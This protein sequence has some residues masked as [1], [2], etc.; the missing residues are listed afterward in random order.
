MT[1]S[2]NVIDEQ[3][4]Y[5]KK[6]EEKLN[7]R[8]KFLDEFYSNKYQTT[9][10]DLEQKIKRADEHNWKLCNVCA[11]LIQ[12]IDCL[13]TNRVISSELNIHSIDEISDYLK[14]SAFNRALY[15]VNDI[16]ISALSVVL[17]TMKQYTNL[18]EFVDTLLESRPAAKWAIEKYRNNSSTDAISKDSEGI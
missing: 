15:K 6:K 2:K 8:E 4:E 13:C 5:L 17:D 11:E 7:A 10:E 3:L 12:I 9:V 1:E 14:S 16:N 18:N